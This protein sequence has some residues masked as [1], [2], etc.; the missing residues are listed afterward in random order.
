M[1]AENK[2][3]APR[4]VIS[5]VP[6]IRQ[7]PWER[8]RQREEVEGRGGREE[9]GRSERKEG[10]GW[11]GGEVEEVEQ[12]VCRLIVIRNKTK[13]PLIGCQTILE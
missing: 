11:G 9:R 4:A 12:H 5:C 8:G 3:S 7:S 1:S 13:L 10:G 6:L 2:A